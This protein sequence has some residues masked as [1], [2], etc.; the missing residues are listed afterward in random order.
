MNMSGQTGKVAL[1]IED[2]RDYSSFLVQLFNLRGFH[3]FA[4]F[5]FDGAAA[6][7]ADLSPDIITL[8]IQLEGRSG[9]FLFHRLRSLPNTKGTPVIV[10][11]GLSLKSADM[12][13]LMREFMETGDLVPPS[14][15]VEKPVDGPK[16]IELALTL[17]GDS[18]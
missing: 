13:I 6:L 16:L 5:D 9:L 8:D 1:I 7:A 17:L 10:V 3:A 15:Y 18:E 4:A 12:E 2:D 11:S 14:A